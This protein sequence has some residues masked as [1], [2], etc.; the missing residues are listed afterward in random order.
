MK[1]MGWRYNY[2]RKTLYVDGHDKSAQLIYRKDMCENY[3][4]DCD[5]RSHMW[6]KIKE[7]KSLRLKRDGHIPDD[8]KSYR[9][10]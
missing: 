3:L 9:Y 2:W 7:E 1:M 8:L 6:M 10:K 5:P 4:T